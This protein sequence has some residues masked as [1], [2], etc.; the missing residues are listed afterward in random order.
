M[1]HYSTDDLYP[2]DSFLMSDHQL[3][4][5]CQ[6]QP[7]QPMYTPSQP[8]QLQQQLQQPQQYQHHPQFSHPHAQVSAQQPQQR[9]EYTAPVSRHIPSTR[10]YSY[11]PYAASNPSPRVSRYV[12]PWDVQVPT[13]NDYVTSPLLDYS[14]YGNIHAADA[15]SFPLYT[16]TTV[17][18][19]QT[20]QL[21]TC[22]APEDL[23][24][25]ISPSLPDSED[26]SDSP[27]STDNNSSSSSSS[28]SVSSRS[29][30]TRPGLQIPANVSSS[31]SISSGSSL[32]PSSGLPSPVDSISSNESEQAFVPTPSLRKSSTKNAG[33]KR[34]TR[35]AAPEPAWVEAVLA[36]DAKRI[37]EGIEGSTTVS[38]TTRPTNR[39]I[40]FAC[41]FCRHRKIQCIRPKVEAAPG[42]KPLPC[43]S[44][45]FSPFVCSIFCF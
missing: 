25:P 32:A 30:P 9:Y 6:P 23:F 38:S 28:A 16:P 27:L 8:Q 33:A 24:T 35:S 15:L 29:T 5:H 36:E 26:R 42:E 39:P 20:I 11:H 31:T 10:A 43:K 7:Q 2:L 12:A 13:L 19:Y 3:A 4:F 41:V 1:Q 22:I 37:Q 18:P 17:N 40:A 45:L 34:S 21:P 14:P 44:V